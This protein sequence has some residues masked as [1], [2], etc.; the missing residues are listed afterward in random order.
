MELEELKSANDILQQEVESIKNR[1]ISK[2]SEL[3]ERLLYLQSQNSSLESERVGLKSELELVKNSRQD[4]EE[5]DKALLTL[6]SKWNKLMIVLK[7]MEYERDR[8]LDEAASMYEFDLSREIEQEVGAAPL[9]RIRKSP[10][11]AQK[12]GLFHDFTGANGTE[13]ANGGEPAEGWNKYI[14]GLT[15]EVDSY[16][17]INDGNGNSN[18]NG[19]SPRGKLVSVTSPSLE[20]EEIARGEELAALRTKCQDIEAEAERTC[21]MLVEKAVACQEEVVECMAMLQ[22]FEGLKSDY[23]HLLPGDLAEITQQLQDCLHL[24]EQTLL[25]R[26]IP[27]APEDRIV[28]EEKHADDGAICELSRQVEDCINLAQK[29]ETSQ[30]VPSGHVI[31]EKEQ[32]GYTEKV[33]NERDSALA[34]LKSLR[35]QLA[36][37]KSIFGGKAPLQPRG[38]IVEETMNIQSGASPVSPSRSVKIS[39]RGGNHTATP[40][41]SSGSLTRSILATDRLSTPAPQEINPDSPL[42]T[43]WSDK[44]WDNS[45]VDSTLPPRPAKLELDGVSPPEQAEGSPGEV[46]RGGAALE[47]TM[48][49]RS[50]RDSTLPLSQ[51]SSPSAPS[52]SGSHADGAGSK[53]SQDAV[54]KRRSNSGKRFVSQMFG[55]HSK[56]EAE[57]SLSDNNSDF[58]SEDED[59]EEKPKPVTNVMSDPFTAARNTATRSRSSTAQSYQHVSPKTS[60]LQYGTAPPAPPINLVRPGSPHLENTPSADYQTSWPI[61]DS[62]VASSPPEIVGD[63]TD[64][65]QTVGAS[66]PFPNS[67][68]M[69]DNNGLLWVAPAKEEAPPTVDASDVA[70]EEDAVD[71]KELKSQVEKLRDEKA[72]AQAKV[73][74]L[75]NQLEIERDA[76]IW[77]ER[78]HCVTETEL[79]RV[80]EAN[81]ELHERLAVLTA[82]LESAQTQL[83]NLPQGEAVQSTE[84]AP[85]TIALEQE[86]ESCKSEIKSLRS[87]LEAAQAQLDARQN[88]PRPPALPTGHAPER[89]REPVMRQ[90]GGVEKQ[91]MDLRAALTSREL[92]IKNLT[93]QLS[94]KY[95]GGFAQGPVSHKPRRFRHRQGRGCLSFTRRFVVP[96]LLVVLIAAVVALGFSSADTPVDVRPPPS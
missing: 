54:K 8:A 64:S 3:E 35:Q 83:A 14:Q 4:V 5:K 53:K 22:D 73:K 11:Q 10:P 34:E 78:Q 15:G 62:S 50:H 12:P 40:A 77:R 9:R 13:T 25:G 59:P 38:S 70:Q 36:L 86:L 91:L 82:S 84:M 19:L 90:T 32:D 7:R 2:V 43:P 46:G 23:E 74:E 29:L 67:P 60:P 16:R 41:S 33:V 52:A 49:E 88:E 93:E 51:P 96:N 55:I 81:E 17:I 95:Y 39:P 76:R 28:V 63:P 31:E 72:K 58:A 87:R 75:E 94:N 6:S 89:F 20:A 92:D 27:S 65:M 37:R 24:S 21:E 30:V 18:G 79:E 80:I 26:T 66:S 85:D 45:K 47:P 57:V 44:Y 48:R 68:G 42:V 69:N 71:T 1:E 56:I 61:I